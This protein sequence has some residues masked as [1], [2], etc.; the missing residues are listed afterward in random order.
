MPVSSADRHFFWRSSGRVRQGRCDDANGGIIHAMDTVPNP[1]AR[2]DIGR[3]ESLALR[4]SLRA[5][6][7]RADS[8]RAIAHTGLS[9][10]VY[11]DPLSPRQ[12]LLA[13]AGVYRTLALPAHALRDNLLVDFDTA[14]LTSGTVLQVGRDV[15][16][17]LMFQCEACGHL[18]AHQPGLSARIGARRGMLARVI[19]GGVIR[20]GDRI[21]DVG[22]LLPAWSDD[23][24][25]RVVQVLDA[26][27]PGAVVTYK[28]LAHLAGV[29]STYCRAFPRMTA[30]L[31]PG[32]AAKAV[33]AQTPD[34][35]ATHPRWD[36]TGLFDHVLIDSLWPSDRPDVDAA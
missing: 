10:D 8:V 2:M 32:Y 18:D 6:P 24:R 13:G 36:G 19:R 20:P 11:A 33:S 9:G 34:V 35:P 29:A 12:L 15:L 21:R 22:L 28:R 27:P 17:R 5:A 26:V 7:K 25:E 14:Q 4:P 16:L 23:W 3:I 31:G 1:G 30:K